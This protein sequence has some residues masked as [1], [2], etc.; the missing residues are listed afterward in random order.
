WTRSSECWPPFQWMTSTISPAASSTSVTI[1]VIS[2]RTSRWHIRIVVLGAFHAV[3]RSSASAVRSG[4]A[5][6]AS[7]S[8]IPPSRC[9]HVSTP[10]SLP[11]FLQLR[12]D[13]AIVGIAS[14]IATFCQRCIVLGLPQLQLD[15]APS[16][17]VLVSHHALGL[18]DRFD[19][20]R[21][22]GAQHLGGDRLIDA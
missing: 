20:H 19:R 4:R 2:A 7:G 9:R 17:L 22:D 8:G 15:N 6:P 11:R 14:G 5:A 18:L 16:V 10:C 12:C 3:E 13:Q 21:R 1:S